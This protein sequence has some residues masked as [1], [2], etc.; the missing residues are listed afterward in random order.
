MPVP[1]QCF[2]IVRGKV[3]RATALD[4][5]CSINVDSPPAC[6]VVVSDGLISVALTAEIEAGE[7]IRDRNWAGALCAVDRSPDQFLYWNVEITFCSVDPALISLLTGNP[8]EIDDEG[9]LVGFRTAEGGSTNNVAIEMWSGTTPT[10]CG[11][12]EAATYGYT[13]LPCLSGGRMGDFTLE[14]GRADFIVSGAFTK[15]GEGWGSGPYDVI[16]DGG[17]AAPLETAIQS[18]EH[19]LLRRTD[20]APPS[21]DCTCYTLEEAGGTRPTS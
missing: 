13:L 1:S 20:V 2:N 11:P 15:S 10:N 21:A 12:G 9:D 19:H 7:T 18:G 17:V 6:E 8:L 4:D 14:N 5:C 3:L 16:T